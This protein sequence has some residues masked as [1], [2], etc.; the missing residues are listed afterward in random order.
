ML[1]GLTLGLATVVNSIQVPFREQLYTDVSGVLLERELAVFVNSAPGDLADPELQDQLRIRRES[2]DR[3]SRGLL[4]TLLNVFVAAATSLGVG[5]VLV[6]V[7]PLVA[8]LMCCAALAPLLVMGRIMR[9]WRGAQEDSATPQRVFDDLFHLGVQPRAFDAIVQHGGGRRV[10]GESMQMW[11][12]VRTLLLRAQRQEAL[13]TLVSALVT[14]VFVVA[15]LLVLLRGHD[16]SVGDMAIVA[17]SVTA[18]GTL[19][20]MVVW[21]SGV[22]QVAQFV[23]DLDTTLVPSSGVAT[24]IAPSKQIMAVDA[25]S[26]TFTYRGRTEP[27]VDRANGR[28]T[29]TGMNVLTGPNGAGKST[30]A[31]LLTGALHPDTGTICWRRA[32]GSDGA[33]CWQEV[34][35]LHQDEPPLPLPVRDFVRMGVDA[36]DPEIVAALRSTG[37]GALVDTVPDLLDQRIGEGYSQGAAFS[38]GQYQRLCL[39]RLLLQDRPMWLLDEP[40]S[41]IDAAGDADFLALLRKVGANRFILVITHKDLPLEDGDELWRIEGGRPERLP[42]PPTATAPGPGA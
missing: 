4:E 11:R 14:T 32:D 28:F 29:G 3:R 7:S 31:K 12:T 17:S 16:V 19:T 37:L 5:G 23:G 41:A 34:S 9:V 26:A 27:A 8:L 15:A 40:T 24:P 20:Q 6:S 36:S 38:G 18:L 22:A 2:A 13:L 21:G 35:V 25:E 33:P 30:L 1:L 42:P 10:R 39:A